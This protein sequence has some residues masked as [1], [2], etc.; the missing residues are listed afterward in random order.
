MTRTTAPHTLVV[1]HRSGIGDLVWH[2]P[3]LRAIAA[4]SRDGRIVLMARPSSRAADLLAGETCI[5][6]VIEFD[7]RP[8]ASERRRGRHDSLAAQWALVGELRRQRF[9]RVLIFA[10][11]PRY[12]VLAWLAGIP[13]RAG[14]GFSAAERLW[15]NEPPYIRPHT[16][17]GNW[18]YPEA[19]AF[20]L[21]HGFVDG[22]RLPRLAVRDD[23]LQSAAQW[24]AGLT[25]PVALS[26]GSSEP[27]KHWGDDRFAALAGALAADGQSVVLVGGPAEA[28]SAA[29]IAAAVPAALQPRVRTLTQ[30][31]VQ[32]S[33]AVLRHARLCVGND[34][35]VL[36]IA[37]AVEVPALGLFGATPP[38]RHDPLLQAVEGR[39]MASIEVPEVLARVRTMLETRAVA[40]H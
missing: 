28:D 21:A 5:A 2:L 8:R 9:D 38:L 39:D 29:R 17:A 40:Q 12:G 4:T 27:R 23:A 26:I 10:S 37:V 22:P 18:V 34:T 33:A 7:H 15:L 36:N 31:S 19:T 20:A 14:F 6:E 24:L 3:Y 16:G 35:G 32:L 1:H 13:R 25:A 11:R 30:P